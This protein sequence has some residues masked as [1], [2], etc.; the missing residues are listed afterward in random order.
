MMM[1]VVVVLTWVLV[2][3]F[4]GVR[5][6]YKTTTLILS[7]IPHAPPTLSITPKLLLTI[8]PS[9]HSPSSANES[10]FFE[11]HVDKIALFAHKNLE[12]L[13]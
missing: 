7:E 3:S 6:Y 8:A 4:T 5:F 12:S 10:K 2:S 9:H 1:M 13:H 11:S